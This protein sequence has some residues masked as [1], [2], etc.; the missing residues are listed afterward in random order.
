[1]AAQESHYEGISAAIHELRRDL[2]ERFDRKDEGLERRMENL[3]HQSNFLRQEM[4]SLERSQE[5]GFAEV[6]RSFQMLLDRRDVSLLQRSVNETMRRLQGLE[7]TQQEA[8]RRVQALEDGQ[9]EI[10]NTLQEILSRL[11]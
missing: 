3:E 4:R 5:S 7:E 10:K 11:R 2:L 1:L 9:Q 8:V 6:H